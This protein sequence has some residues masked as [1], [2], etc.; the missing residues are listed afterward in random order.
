ME[1]RFPEYKKEEIFCTKNLQS[2]T[3][4]KILTLRLQVIEFSIPGGRG[5]PDFQNFGKKGREN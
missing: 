1:Q 5:R 4:I 3:S 2:F